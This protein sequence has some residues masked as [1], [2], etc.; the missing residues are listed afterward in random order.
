MNDIQTIGHFSKK[1]KLCRTCWNVAYALL[2]R[3]FGTPLLWWWRRWILIAFGAK[4]HRTAHVYSSVRITAPWN[5][6][7]ERD[8]CLAPHVVCYNHAM[9]T[10]M[11]GATVSQYSVL[12]T[13]GHDYTTGKGAHS[14]VIIAPI[15]LRPHAWVTSNSFVNL[16]VEV[17]EQAI[18]G[19]AAAV[20]KD[21]EP[22]TI[23]GGNPA[24]VIKTIPHPDI[25]AE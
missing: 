3:P 10:L 21:V 20:F 16:G 4:V 24:R 25:D 8:T 15:T 5:L 9:V 1:D 2:F 17:G 13:A 18:V 14:E 19:A 7:M 6:R 12:C 11:E 23:V 22:Y